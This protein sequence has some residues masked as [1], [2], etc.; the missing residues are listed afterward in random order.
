MAAFKG[1][2]FNKAK[3]AKILATMPHEV[4]IL[5]ENV[6]FFEDFKARAGTVSFQREY[7]PDADEETLNEARV[8]FASVFREGSNFNYKTPFYPCDQRERELL[9]QGLVHRFY[10]LRATLLEYMDYKDTRIL[11]KRE[12]YE[13]LMRLKDLI[14]L[15]DRIYDENNGACMD[16]YD[17]ATG[18]LREPMN[19]A[20]QEALKNLLRQFVFLVLQGSQPLDG[21][22][23]RQSMDAVDFL[24]KLKEQTI[25]KDDMIEYMRQRAEAG[26]KTIPLYLDQLMKDIQSK[27]LAASADCEEQLLQVKKRLAGLIREITEGTADFD[28]ASRRMAEIDAKKAGAQQAIF[29]LIQLLGELYRRLQKRLDEC[30][31][32]ARDCEEALRTATKR[33]TQ[34]QQEIEELNKQFEQRP[35][36]PPSGATLVAAPTDSGKTLEQLTSPEQGRPF[37]PPDAVSVLSDQLST[38]KEELQRQR[39]LAEGV[40][41][42]AAKAQGR[43]AALEAERARLQKNFGALQVALEQARSELAVAVADVKAKGAE[44]AE[45][46]TQKK[47][48][49]DAKA[50]LQKAADDAQAKIAALEAAKKAEL[51]DLK[52]Q[53]AAASAELT[54]QIAKL[55]GAAAAPIA[56]KRD[57]VAIQAEQTRRAEKGVD[58]ASERVDELAAQVA[59]AEARAKAEEQTTAGLRTQLSEAKTSIQALTAQLTAAKDQGAQGNQAQILELERQLTAAREEGRVA[60]VRL[61]QSEQTAADIRAL[62]A[63]YEGRLEAAKKQKETLEAELATLKANLA[64]EQRKFS[65]LVESMN[66]K[67]SDATASHASEMEALR[68]A[69]V[70]EL[71]KREADLASKISAERIRY[72]EELAAAKQAHNEAQEALKNKAAE[73]GRQIASL[74]TEIQTQQSKHRVE[75]AEQQRK[76]E[77]ELGRLQEALQKERTARAELQGKLDEQIALVGARTK[78]IATLKATIAKLETTIKGKDAEIE[79]VKGEREDLKFK[80]RLAGEELEGKEA[81]VTAANAKIEGLQAEL[82]QR[83]ARI[84]ALNDTVVGVEETLAELRDLNTRLG[85]EKEAV[86]AEATAAQAAAAAAKQEA[87]EAKAETGE[88]ANTLKQYEEAA[89]RLQAEGADLKRRLE[90]QAAAAAAAQAERDAAEAAKADSEM[91]LRAL[92]EG[93]Q[94]AQAATAAAEARAVSAN[95]QAA[96]TVAAARKREQNAAQRTIARAF[97]GARA[98]RAAAAVA[99]PT[100]EV[101]ATAAT[102]AALA[103]GAENSGDGEDPSPVAQPEAERPPLRESGQ[104]FENDGAAPSPAANLFGPVEEARQRPK[105]ERPTTT[106]APFENDGAAP[107]PAANL[108]GTDTT[109]AADIKPPEDKDYAR[110][111]L[112]RGASR[113]DVEMAWQRMAVKLHPK[114]SGSNYDNFTNLWRSYRRIVAFMKGKPRPSDASILAEVAAKVQR[115]PLSK[116][117]AK[118]QRA[119]RVGAAAA[120]AGEARPV[121]PPTGVVSPSTRRRKRVTQAA[122][123]AAVG[124]DTAASTAPVPATAPVAPR[125]TRRQQRQNWIKAANEK[126]SA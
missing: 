110:L 84:G 21:W 112:T 56:A 57:D 89:S 124:T 22:S 64:A 55:Q 41:E 90:T 6:R 33:L 4:N 87:E 59:R 39:A 5:G 44:L 3:F 49:E 123:N 120:A 75:I 91:R 101:P 35:L 77:L 70:A 40:G 17:P 48:A 115:Q 66:K 78:E 114:N 11:E 85:E 34:T 51:A 105:R 74:T 113:E 126:I 72:N 27:D 1:K 88:V 46:K 60:A 7:F 80:L 36:F 32:A 23:D 122:Y 67:L 94:G 106:V 54:K 10:T 99:P 62:K 31:E 52:A 69:Q 30:E 107:S 18:R 76:H 96:A 118:T 16:D 47:A 121:L 73:L 50:A 125:K 82:E 25:S 28:L 19:L 58:R 15:M 2:W 116:R 103:K 108:F 65:D 83:N 100:V 24:E 14:E 42:E 71:A 97:R 29:D 45:L 68:Q 95:A 79:D 119:K 98:R 104:L 111:G 37:P 20:D 12:A 43:I 53:H 86:A 92:E 8:I 109:A 38:V 117:Q 81:E 61:Q 9:K 26:H 93:L 13:H 63:D 102:A